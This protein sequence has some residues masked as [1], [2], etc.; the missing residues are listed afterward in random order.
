MPMV[1]AGIPV[2][3]RGVDRILSCI[4]L[5]VVLQGLVFDPLQGDCI[6]PVRCSAIRV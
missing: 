3:L 6:L 1:L 2:G 5:W 4:F